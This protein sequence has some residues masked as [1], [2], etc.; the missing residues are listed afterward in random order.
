MK[1]HYH[2]TEDQTGDRSM[3]CVVTD[4]CVVSDSVDCTMDSACVISRV[5]CR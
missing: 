1:Y 2:S 5:P 4:D 3:A